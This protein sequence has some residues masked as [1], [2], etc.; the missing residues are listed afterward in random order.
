MTWKKSGRMKRKRKNRFLVICLEDERKFDL[1]VDDGNVPLKLKSGRRSSRRWRK[2]SFP[3]DLLMKAKL[4]DQSAFQEKGAVKCEGV[5][6]TKA[7]GMPRRCYSSVHRFQSNWNWTAIDGAGWDG[8]N[9]EAI[10]PEK[11]L[12]FNEVGKLWEVKSHKFS[13]LW[14]LFEWISERLNE[15]FFCMVKQQK[16]LRICLW[17]KN[18]WAIVVMHGW[19]AINAGL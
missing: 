9:Q 1:S 19:T 3:I 13:W 12:N 15:P 6:W 8:I 10:D 17:N 5:R 14:A 16:G 4:Q 11:V 18:Y 7:S 2:Q